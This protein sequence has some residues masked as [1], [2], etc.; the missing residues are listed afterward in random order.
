MFQPFGHAYFVLLFA[1]TKSKKD[2]PPKMD[3]ERVAYIVLL[4]AILIIGFVTPFIWYKLMKNKKWG[5][6]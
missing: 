1:H 2:V 3:V 4:S 5:T 6:K